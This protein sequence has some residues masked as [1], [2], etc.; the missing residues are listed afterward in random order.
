MEKRPALGKGLSALIP[1]APEPRISPVEVAGAIGAQN[2]TPRLE[3]GLP[4][5][6]LTRAT[7]WWSTDVSSAPADSGSAGYIAYINNGSPRPLHPD[8]GGTLDDGIPIYGFGMML[9]VTFVVCTWVAGR[10]A[11]RKRPKLRPPV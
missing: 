9:F 2:M 7:N 10:R 8:F 1:D 3:G 6:N 11:G 5:P 4:G